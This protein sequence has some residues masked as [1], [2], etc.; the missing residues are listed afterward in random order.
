MADQTI[1]VAIG[2]VEI[3][4]RHRKD[5]GDLG[6][7]AASIEDVGLL[8]PIVLTSSLRLVAGHRRLE[9]CRKL[10]W[11]RIAAVVASTL[12]D[13]RR[14]LVAEYDENT[15]RLE[16]SLLEKVSIGVAIEAVEQP[17]AKERQAAAGPSEGRGKKTGP[18]KIPE[19]VGTGRVRDIVGE[20][21]KMSGKSYQRAKAV[22]QAATDDT[23]APEVR[24]V[25]T[26]ALSDMETT[27]KVA[28]AYKKLCAA[29]QAA[30]AAAATNGKPAKKKAGARRKAV[31]GESV[32]SRT[33]RA[34]AIGGDGNEARK[35]VG[36]PQSTYKESRYLVLLADAELDGAD[37]S[38]ASAALAAMNEDGHTGRAYPMVERLVNAMWG[39][40]T[41]RSRARPDRLA[42]SRKKDFER[43]YDA[44]VHI[45]TCAAAIT[46]PLLSLEDRERCVSELDAAADQVRAFRDRIKEAV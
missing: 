11:K 6:G 33:R 27:G 12:D 9:A 26:E 13:A 5:L 22:V 19:P 20:A 1:D 8:Q 29:K 31:Q 38:A 41:E 30:K 44:V 40:P 39:A 35:T 43:A 21:V 25:A 10:G 45:C 42:T 23:L 15:Q 37:R 28:P 2:D 3:R 34:M 16:P 24:A 14:M 7:L 18:G 32:E 4:D 17:K 46:I 36:L